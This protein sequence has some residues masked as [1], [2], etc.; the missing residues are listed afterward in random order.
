MMRLRQLP[1]IVL[2]VPFLLAAAVPSA[3]D[4]P[5]GA[6]VCPAAPSAASASCHAPAQIESAGCRGPLKASGES[7]VAAPERQKIDV[8]SSVP[9]SPAA[10]SVLGSPCPRSARSA[11]AH[12][13]A[14]SPSIPLS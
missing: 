2:G 7:A 14:S 9:L 10:V 6:C 12:T 11:P 4:C 8:A 3:S 1:V 5:K 13:L